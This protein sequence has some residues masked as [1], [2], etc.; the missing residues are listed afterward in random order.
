MNATRKEQLNK[1]LGT[2]FIDSILIVK[3]HNYLL[4]ADEES[5][6]AIALNDFQVKGFPNY[7]LFTYCLKEKLIDQKSLYIQ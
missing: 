7:A 4:L 1:S 5:L 3:E 6:R 2:A